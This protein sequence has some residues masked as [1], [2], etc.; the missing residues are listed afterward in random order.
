MLRFLTAGESHGQALVGIIEGLPAGVEISQE[1]IN[2]QLS[3][4]RGGYG[5]GGRMNIEADEVRVVSGVRNGKTLG[6]PVALL[7]ENR[8]YPNWEELMS[9]GETTGEGKSVIRPRPGHADLAGG[10]KYA[11]RDMRNVL[12]RAS[13][14]ETAMRVALGA[15]CR[16][17]L[18][19]F[20]IRIYSQ[21]ISIGAVRAESIPVDMNNIDQV[22]ATVEASPVYCGHRD[23]S[24]QMVDE[25]QKAKQEGESLG[26]SFEVGVLNLPPGLG[27]YGQWD[28]RLDSR[29]SAALMSIP[30]IKAVEIG[31]GFASSEQPGSR[32][33]DEILYNE[34]RGLYR[35][36][37]RA[38][39]IEGGITN[40]E[41]V[42][43]RA[44]MKPIPTLYR[45]L[46]SVN[47]RTWQVETAQVERSDICAVP[48]A[49]VVG[50]AVTAWVVADAFLE[51]F[52]GDGL[53]EIRANYVTYLDYLG[54]VWQWKRT[55]Y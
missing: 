28:R 5:R 13:A 37:N 54:R 33:H 22:M 40:G 9:P 12:E 47:T 10:M 16:R 3:R 50:E 53:E 2:R 15:V 43:A 39:G 41:K 18:E 49:A 34:N 20:R 36:T 14:R 6:S 29:L 23:K 55:L 26:G 30:A 27:S 51:K 45:P 35:A 19:E 1:Y 46:T 42:W 38:G 8:D 52:G 25:I 44:Y 32:V 11:H 48:A 17:V 31:E 24:I 21:V 7:I 4:R